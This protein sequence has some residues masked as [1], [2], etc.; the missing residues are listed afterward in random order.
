MEL[1]AS[2]RNWAIA[3]PTVLATQ[4]GASAFER[5]GNAVDAALA[6]A[7]VLA[8]T[9]PHNCG[10]GT[11]VPGSL[12]R[13]LQTDGEHLA[14]DPG[15]RAVFFPDGKPM[16]E[17]GLLQQPALGATLQAIAAEGADALYRGDV[18]A[19]YVEG[20]RAAGSPM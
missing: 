2:G 17:G 15:I 9:Y 5:G 18:G 3:S 13:K 4:A 6:A 20:L 19:R 8:V 1:H 7:T 12:A 14:A 11:D 16:A 10:D